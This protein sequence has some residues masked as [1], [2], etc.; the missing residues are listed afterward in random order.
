MSYPLT[1]PGRTPEGPAALMAGERL[2]EVRPVAGH[3]LVDDRPLETVLAELGAT[4]LP[5][6][7][8]VLAV[9]SNTCPAQLRRKFSGTSPVVPMMAVRVRG[10]AVGASAHISRPGYVPATPI[11][12][13]A[14]DSPLW[15]I[16]PDDAQL[17]VLDATE[18]NYHRIQVPVPVILPSSSTPLPDCG[19]YVSRH[20]YLTNTGGTPRRLGTQTELLSGL[21]RDIP[22]LAGLAGLNPAAIAKAARNSADLRDRIRELFRTE[23]L[24]R[25]YASGWSVGEGDDHV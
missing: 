24:V 16:W 11:P 19:I 5:A 10:I 12:D 23:E 18:P 1:Y 14:A 20:G 15:V 17:V 8:P 13:P 2:F 3:W 22:S 25:R 21:I 7:H 9:G 6:R 4:P